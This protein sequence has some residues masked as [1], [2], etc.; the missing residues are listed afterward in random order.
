[1]LKLEEISFGVLAH[2]RITNA[3]GKVTAKLERISG[4]G[5]VCLEGIDTT[6]RPF[7]EWVAQDR[8]ELDA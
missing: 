3:R 1:M 5:S 8:I 7:T 6:G 2:D 4:P